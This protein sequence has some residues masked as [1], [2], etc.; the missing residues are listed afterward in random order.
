[1]EAVIFKEA[2]AWTEKLQLDRIEIENPL[3]NEV[4]INILARPI[5]PS[6]E[7]FIQ[8]NYRQKPDFPQIA[9]LEAAGI[10][11]KVGKNIDGK[12]IGQHVAFRAKGTWTEKINLPEKSFRFVPKEVPFEVAC[13]LSLNVFT[14]YALIER[15][16]LTHGQWLLLTAANS[17]LSKQIIQLA[18]AK[19]INVIAVIRNAYYKD[20]LFQLGADQVL[21]SADP[22]LERQILDIAPIGVNA[23]LDA[24][25]GVLGS[26]ISRVAAPFGKIIVYGRLDSHD[27]PFSYGTIIYK[28]LNIAGFGIDSWMVSKNER[29]LDVI[30]EQ[31]MSSVVNNNLHLGYEKKFSLIDFKEAILFYKETGLKTILS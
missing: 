15:S 28:N 5:N 31:L 7:M 24:V 4:Q 1:M 18:K 12:L 8:G 10:V 11:A 2:G 23:I 19:G 13:Q 3:E 14:A 29:D 26:I 27:T 22:D 25:G 30:W 9:G 17:S 6:D 21:N 20:E 16:E